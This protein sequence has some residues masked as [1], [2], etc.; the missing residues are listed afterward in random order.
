MIIYIVENLKNKKVYIGK[1]IHSLQN[2]KSS[3]LFATKTNRENVYFH[4]A[5]KK[6]GEDSFSWTT[7][8]H[9]K[10]KEELNL[11]EKHLKSLN[12]NDERRIAD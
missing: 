4:S 6:Y 3:H 1:T 9:C 10:S 11:M 8:C 5:L 2:R 12:H 7:I